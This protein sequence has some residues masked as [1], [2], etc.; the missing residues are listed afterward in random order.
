MAPE[1]FE[2]ATSLTVSS[3]NVR[4]SLRV[5]PNEDNA[6]ATVE[7]IE[8]ILTS[9]GIHEDRRLKPAIEALVEQLRREPDA[10]AEAVVAEGTA[11]THGANG[12]FELAP[13]LE[14]PEPPPAASSD[15]TS[16]DHYA[17]T[18]IVV[19]HQDQKLGVLHAP[20]DPADGIDVY[21]SPIKATAGQEA[22]LRCDESVEM[23]AGGVLFALQS[24]CLHVAEGRIA[25]EAMLEIDESVD[26]GTGNVDF[27]G[28][29]Q[30][31][32]GVRDK[33]QV[34]VG[35]DLE[36]H[37]LVEAAY[38]D[39]AGSTTLHRGM[40]GR[41]KGTLTVGG[42]V[43]AGYLDATN[44]DVGHDLCV[45]KELSNCI[46]TVGRHVRSPECVVVSGELSFRFGA[47]VRTLGGEAETE[48]LV[49]IGCD[50]GLDA[51]TRLL[52]ETLRDTSGRLEKLRAKVAEAGSGAAPEVEAEI[53]R[54]QSR[55]PS[56]RMAL[57]RVL[58]A[59]ERMSGV[60]LR[61]EKSIM[62]GVT[63][64]IGT[65]AATVRQAISGP[66]EVLLDA[67]DAMVF[68]SP[69]SKS[70][71]PLASK[72]VMHVD[73]EAIDLDDLRRWLDSALLRPSEKAA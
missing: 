54:L 67:E 28:D 26:F 42:N 27:P 8:A 9:Q 43:S 21:G 4:A 71:T 44:V 6:D 73:R 3:D 38:L 17:H 20:T 70:T 36:V 11:P 5:E 48:T 29:V 66:V 35:G 72:A 69:G 34:T 15:D 31:R 56:I 12:R 51:Q 57:E 30:V 2:Q 24:G 49:R 1:A 16:V 59:Y 61:V 40:A 14:P 60:V 62:P 25:V 50:P 32:E 58:L 37:E 52:E 18:S 55:A 41:G 45:R 22:P 64:S 19:V 65:Q 63:L 46:T 39:V 68:R 13:E 33:F 10:M 23:R 47:H 53:A 7:A